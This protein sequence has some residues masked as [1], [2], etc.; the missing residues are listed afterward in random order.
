MTEKRITGTKE[1]AASNEKMMLGCQHDCLYC[2]AKASAP[3]H[4]KIDI[5]KWA[6]AFV[7]EKRLLKNIGKRKGTIMF[8]TTHDIHPDNLSDTKFF[9]N[10]LLR[11][12]N[13]VLIVSKPHIECIQSICDSFKHY[14]EQILFRFTI[15]SWD[16]DVL[17]YWEP[18]APNFCERV[19]SLQYAYN[20][21]YKTSVSMEPMLDREPWKTIIQV[22]KYVKDSIWLGKMNDWRRRLKTNGHDVSKM[23]PDLIHMIEH[24]E[25][26]DN[27]WSLYYQ[28]KEDPL[29]KWKESI[30]TVVGIAPAEQAGMDI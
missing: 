13:K 10:K 18:G 19:S 15:G 28:Y 26:D 9:L 25:N 23:H 22:R 21:G 27:I 5:D 30:K 4:G 1:W 20:S 16:D 17:K 3:R 11:P 12:G 14:R 8:P 24:W 6:N 2:Y 7:W 29:I